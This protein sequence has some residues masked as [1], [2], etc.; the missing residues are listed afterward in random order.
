MTIQQ[1]ITKLIEYY[2]DEPYLYLRDILGVEPSDQQL[3]LIESV[4][5]PGS[6]TTVRAG[7]GVGKTTSLAWLIL[8]FLPTHINCVIPCTAP[9]G[10]QLMDVL[11]PEVHKWHGRMNPVFKDH[12]ILSND[13]IVV[14]G[15]EKTQFAVART[16]RKEKPDALQG[17]HDDN[18]L[19]VIDEASGV[20]ETVLEV[21]LG[22]LSK[23]NSRVVMTG[24][25]V[26]TEGFFY[27]SHTAHREFWNTMHFSCLDSP[28]VDDNYP[29]MMRRQYGEDSPIYK[30]RVL[31]EFPDSS[32]D[33]IIPL[34]LVESAIDRD[35]DSSISQKIAGLDI[36][37]FGDDSS[38]I[39]VR[40]GP[41][42]TY[43][44]EWNK[45]DLMST[46]GRIMNLWRGKVFDV[47]YV[48][49]IGLG[50][51]VADRLKEL[52]CPVVE[53]NVAESSSYDDRYQR[54]RDELWWLA[55]E[56]FE[57]LS[58]CI[59]SS[60][61]YFGE[62]QGQLTTLR[63]GFTSTGKIKAESKDELKKRLGA[64]GKSPNIADAF[65][66]TLYKGGRVYN[67]VRKKVFVPANATG[68]T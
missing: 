20:E 27:R 30:V 29:E 12:L 49:S 38:A 4:V 18:L 2:R 37:R 54:L 11:W 50:A 13:K 8:W 5:K 36:A 39:V 63:Y 25:P 57:T 33:T 42:I 68:W 52:G 6:K 59:P 43:I 58:V 66:N 10:H 35:I 31:G 28:L 64:D 14:R 60:V 46:V 62:L 55:R 65:C 44:D 32:A 1:E 51:G 47:I 45:Q 9:T 21:A 41:K 22:S 17:F 56:F 3:Q 67:Q 53:V 61:K 40:Q 34:H 24:N 23:A 48:D 7:H 15:A 16:A 19:F 26:R